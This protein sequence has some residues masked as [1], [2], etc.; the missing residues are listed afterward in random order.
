[1]TYEEKRRM[2]AELAKNEH[3][4]AHDVRSYQKPTKDEILMVHHGGKFTSELSLDSL[5]SE[6]TVESV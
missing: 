3:K 2:L 6:T 1:M 5:S 4:H